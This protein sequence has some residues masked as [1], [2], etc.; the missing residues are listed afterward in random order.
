MQPSELISISW[1]TVGVVT[2]L[3]SVIVGV[4]T[5]YLNLF[6]SSRLT[7]TEKDLLTAIEHRFS[8]K[9]VTEVRMNEIYTRIRRLE[10]IIDG[11]KSHG[12]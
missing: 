9:D 8:S 1:S 5:C 11:R 10:E 6:I 4:A 12:A 2:G 7:S 3:V